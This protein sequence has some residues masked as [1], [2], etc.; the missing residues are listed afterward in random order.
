MDKKPKR[1]KIV[2]VG[3]VALTAVALGLFSAVYFSPQLLIL[4]KISCNHWVWYFKVQP[5]LLRDNPHIK[6]YDYYI[7]VDEVGSLLN[8]DGEFEKLDAIRKMPYLDFL[9][10]ENTKLKDLTFLEKMKLEILIIHDNKIEIQDVSSINTLNHL[11]CLAMY[12]LT[13]RNITVLNEKKNYLNTAAFGNIID[14][15]FHKLKVK[16]NSF[17]N[18]MYITPVGRDEIRE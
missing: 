10:L 1:T 11:R 5:Q 3:L 16:A 2:L 14:P 15:E 18:D 8:L 7:S 4:R 6:T 17:V 13:T 9:V 12:N